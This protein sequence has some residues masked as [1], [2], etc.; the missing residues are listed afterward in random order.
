[1]LS[2]YLFMFYFILYNL[3]LKK[4]LHV[5]GQKKAVVNKSYNELFI[6]YYGSVDCVKVHAH[7][8]SQTNMRSLISAVSSSCKQIC[9]LF[10]RF[11]GVFFL[12]NP[13]TESIGHHIP[14]A[15]KVSN[16][17][18]NTVGHLVGRKRKRNISPKSWSRAG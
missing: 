16:S 2:F 6:S 15:I 18:V 4:C 9:F 8:T 11:F 13:L 17:L 14:T 1:M 7:M 10:F 5:Q 3:C 12:R